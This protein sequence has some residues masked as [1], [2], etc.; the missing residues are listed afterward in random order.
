MVGCA[1]AVSNGVGRERR[2]RPQAKL[3]RIWHTKRAGG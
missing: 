1:G 2:A 3:E